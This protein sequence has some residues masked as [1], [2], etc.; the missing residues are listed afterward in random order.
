MV[1][2]DASIPSIFA[3]GNPGPMSGKELLGHRS[4]E[5]LPAFHSCVHTRRAP[6]PAHRCKDRKVA[7]ARRNVFVLP[8]D[9]R[10]SHSYPCAML[11]LILSFRAINSQPRGGSVGQFLPMIC[12]FERRQRAAHIPH[13]GYHF[14][15]HL[16]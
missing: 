6:N 12:L 16:N 13:A 10:C 2:Q 5:Q 14:L 7:E 9:S 8:A 4:P 15:G 11:S 1:L 3:L